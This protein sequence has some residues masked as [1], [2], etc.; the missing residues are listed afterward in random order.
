MGAF[1][2]DILFSPAARK[3]YPISIECKNVEKINIWEAIEQARTNAGKNTPVVVFKKNNEEAHVAIPFKE[4]L[5]LLH[6]RRIG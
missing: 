4:Y 3:I 5:A 2:E 6:N 1:G